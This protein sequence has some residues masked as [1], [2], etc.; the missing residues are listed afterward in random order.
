MDENHVVVSHVSASNVHEI[1]DLA[2]IR[3]EFSSPAR[4]QT[5]QHDV[6]F[7]RHELGSRRLFSKA[8]SP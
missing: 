2:A 7:Y 8:A 4:R 1:G 3:H 5:S 6:H